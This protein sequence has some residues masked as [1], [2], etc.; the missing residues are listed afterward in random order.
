MY[1][2]KGA[3]GYAS[4]NFRSSEFDCWCKNPQCTVTLIHPRLLERLEMLRADVG[5]LAIN[6]GFS[7]GP[8]NLSVGGE[9]YSFHLFGMAAD[10]RPLEAPF[11]KF[12]DAATGIFEDGGIGGYPDRLHLDVR[13][14]PARWGKFPK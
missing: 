14:L 2:A 5:P 8:H 6:R 13:P 9:D 10:V 11:E 1:F 12:F 7:C 3:R 4:R